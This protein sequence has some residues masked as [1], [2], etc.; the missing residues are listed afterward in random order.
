MARREA[1]QPVA[2]L[3][4]QAEAMLEIL[5]L[6]ARF[7]LA[8]LH[9]RVERRRGRPVRLVPRA[10]PALAPHGLWVVAPDADYV[11]Y[12]RG[13]TAARQFQILGHEFG[14]LAFEDDAASPVGGELAALLQAAVDPRVPA[15]VA[16]RTRY[17]EP[18]ER[19]AEVFGSIVVRRIQSWVGPPRPRTAVTGSPGRLGVPAAAAWPDGRR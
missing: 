11:F 19:R 6:P 18:A 16:Q 13:A 14:H 5:G 2:R 15:A 9:G 8:D 7:S 12:D 3:C 17:D 10:L 1:D 4:L